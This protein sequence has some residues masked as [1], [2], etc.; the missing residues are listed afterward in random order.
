V[1]VADLPGRGPDL[2]HAALAVTAG[3]R[4]LHAN[5]YYHPDRAAVCRCGPCGRTLCAESA[6]AAPGDWRCPDCELQGELPAYICGRCGWISRIATPPCPHCRADRELLRR[7]GQPGESWERRFHGGRDDAALWVAAVTWVAVFSLGLASSAPLALHGIPQSGAW[8]VFLFLVSTA[9]GAAAALLSR[10]RARYTVILSGFG[11]ELRRQSRLTQ[12]VAWS[13]VDG[14]TL[15]PAEHPGHLVVN[16]AG[17]DLVVERGV[18]GWADAVAL[19]RQHA[20]VAPPPHM[21]W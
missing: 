11:L 10:R 16:H 9:C 15:G 8:W 14:V 3:S 13:D 18:E 12:V 19:I 17:G 5:C 4:T 1:R 7:G 20:A 2:R 21:A 6:R